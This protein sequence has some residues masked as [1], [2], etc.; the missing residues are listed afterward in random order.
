MSK[1]LSFFA[2]IKLSL[3][4]YAGITV[5]LV[6][7]CLVAA[8]RLQGSKVH[9]LQVQLLDNNLTAKQLKASDQTDAAAAKYKGALEDYFKAGGT[10]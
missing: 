7:G 3:A 4:E 9:K 10:L 5:A 6:I 8:L 1:M 2:S